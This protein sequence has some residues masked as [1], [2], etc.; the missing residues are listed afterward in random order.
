MG[1]SSDSI[2]VLHVDDDPGVG[3][4]T[5]T[6]LERESELLSVD[7]ATSADEGLERLMQEDFDCVVSDYNMPGQKGLN[8]LQAVRA[9]YPALPFIFF[10]GKG[11]EE[12]AS[13]AIS[14]GVT[15]YLQK[16]GGTA[17]YTVLANRIQNVVARYRAEQRADAIQR[18]YQ[19]LI[20][21]T[22]DVIVIVD[23]EGTFDYLSPSA[24]DVLGYQP[25]E[26]LGEN[27][28]EYI[29]PDDRDEAMALFYEMVADPEKR[30]TAEFRLK[31][32]DG[33]W[34]WLEARGRNLLDDPSIEGI[35]VYTRD[36]TKHREYK[37]RLQRQ[38]ERLEKFVSIVSHDLR[39]PM[40]VLV[41]YLDLAEET[42]D[43]E[44]FV[45]CRRAV[46]RMDS[47]IDDLLTLTR[48]GEMVAER[49]AVD[50]AQAV[51]SSWQNVNTESAALRI[52]TEHVIRADESQLHQLIENLILNAIQH[53]GENVTVTVGGLDRGFYVED[54]GPGI[55]AADRGLVFESGYS[56]SDGGTG[57]GLAIVSTIAEAHG[58][59]V[60]VTDGEAGGARFE[61][62]GIELC[63]D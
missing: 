28:F 40:S 48:H 25:E 3:E 22:S 39:N 5:A 51:E 52:E 33:S 8:F 47:L 6:F 57:L 50:L 19:R 20:Q 34:V 62:T 18:R 17:Q 58:W 24:L 38:N 31:Q 14:A 55:P 11:S 37:Q 41:G 29:H 49:K 36:I 1:A 10:T 42:G 13:E 32:N 12:L 61:I 16:G 26:L 2:H 7:T 63:D 44:Y 9:Q 46:E 23:A 4:M 53:G 60:Q 43:S 27:G 30:P 15:E 54:T 35:V 59:D 56:T 21:E 45:R